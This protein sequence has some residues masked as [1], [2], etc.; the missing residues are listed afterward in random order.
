MGAEEEGRLHVLVAVQQVEGA[1]ERDDAKEVNDHPLSGEG[2]KPTQPRR[3]ECESSQ[4]QAGLSCIG[5]LH[6]TRMGSDPT[7]G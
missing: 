3:R 6:W 1:C 2:S 7:E 5:P 4:S